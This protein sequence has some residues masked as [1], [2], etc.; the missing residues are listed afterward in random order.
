MLYET[1]SRLPSPAIM[2][3]VGSFN[4]KIAVPRAKTFTCP[5]RWRSAA[6]CTLHCNRICDLPGEAVVGLA[7]HE[8]EVGLPLDAAAEDIPVVPSPLAKSQP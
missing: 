7:A 8:S 3:T 5:G 4:Q 6:V 2:E 1:L